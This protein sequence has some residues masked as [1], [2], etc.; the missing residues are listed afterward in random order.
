M[1]KQHQMVNA[2]LKGALANVHGVQIKT[3][4]AEDE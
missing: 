2:A 1:L 4:V 3:L